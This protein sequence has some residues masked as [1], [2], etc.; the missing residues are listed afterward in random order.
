MFTVASDPHKRKT[1]QHLQHLRDGRKEE[2]EFDEWFDRLSKAEQAELRELDPPI[3][4]YREM[5]L[6]RYSFPI[7]ANDSKFASADP[8]KVTE[9]VESD[10]WVTRERVQEIVAD[11]LTLLGSSSDKSV[12]HHFD[13]IRI[14]MQTQDAPTQVD[15]AA[16]MGLTK[17]A[18]CVRVQKMS[19]RA[20][21]LSPGIISRMK[22]ADQSAAPVETS[23]EKMKNKKIILKKSPGQGGALRNL[24]PTPL[25]RRGASTTAKKHRNLKAAQQ[26]GIQGADL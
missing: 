6:P 13:I 3:I 8:R 1:L 2:A 17:Q 22:S 10:G 19:A 15:L 5:P 24:L 4:P 16:R 18:V 14:V 23:E 12:Q 7:Y 25:K 20:A 26:E 11:I 9:Q 21:L